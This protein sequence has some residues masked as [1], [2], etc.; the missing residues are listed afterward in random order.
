MILIF[1]LFMAVH[2]S[3]KWQLE[4]WELKLNVIFFLHVLGFTSNI[5]LN[6]NIV[7]WLELSGSTMDSPWKE[8]TSPWN[9][10]LAFSFVK[11]KT[12]A[13][14]S[15]RCQVIMFIAITTKRELWWHSILTC[16]TN[17]SEN[18][19]S[20]SASLLFLSDVMVN[21][22]NLCHRLKQYLIT[23]D[24]AEQSINYTTVICSLFL[25]M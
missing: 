13:H 9:L 6:V 2:I 16:E 19:L 10:K 7:S 11:D 14:T 25:M 4:M 15:L 18:C 20:L 1:S 5:D 3:F 21:I 24:E 12:D 8:L 23:T 17:E 22:Y